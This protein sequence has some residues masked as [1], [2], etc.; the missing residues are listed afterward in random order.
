M[1][2][3]IRISAKSLSNSETFE[4]AAS[5]YQKSTEIAPDD[6]QV[7]L[8]LGVIYINQQQ[9]D[10]AIAA[11]KRTI[12]VDST[13]AEAYNNLARLYAGLGREM[14]QA[15]DLAKRAVSLEPT[16]RYYDTLAYTYYRNTQYAEALE[17][18]QQALALAPDV[19]S[20]Q[21]TPLKNSGGAKGE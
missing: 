18:I 17:A 11:F 3:R 9:F 15:I 12:V 10:P 13:T 14:Q 8:K 7:W 2:R 4:K 21:P 1:C 20:L 5:V 16:A 6:P 19:D